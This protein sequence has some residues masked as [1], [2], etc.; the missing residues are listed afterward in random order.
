MYACNNKKAKKKYKFEGKCK[1]AYGK[2]WGRN[3]KG[4]M[5]WLYY[6]FKSVIEKET[7]RKRK[8]LA[9]HSESRHKVLP[10]TKQQLFSLMWG[11]STVKSTKTY[12]IRLLN[13]WPVPLASN[14]GKKDTSWSS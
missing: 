9:L 4:E 11:I 10:R 1:Q 12:L 2:V 6:N 8:H 14:S 5:S 13:E 3:G 7:N